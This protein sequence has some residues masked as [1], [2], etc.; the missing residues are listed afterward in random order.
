ML[1]I[2]YYQ[3]LLCRQQLPFFLSVLLFLF[4]SFLINVES[5]CVCLCVLLACQ[6]LLCCSVLKFCRICSAYWLSC[7]SL[8]CLAPKQVCVIVGFLSGLLAASWAT[9]AS[10]RVYETA[11]MCLVPPGRGRWTGRGL[12]VAWMRG[13]LCPCGERVGIL[14]S[15]RCSANLGGGLSPQNGHLEEERSS[16]WLRINTDRAS[17]HA[18][19]PSTQ[20]ECTWPGVTWPEMSQTD[21]VCGVCPWLLWSPWFWLI[22]AVTTWGEE[23]L[24]FLSGGPLGVVLSVCQS[25][26]M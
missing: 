8:N 6:L 7:S 13:L 4:F 2:F 14:E 20:S 22:C 3:P 16:D 25:P 18:G 23:A 26:W 17:D 19:L 9:L 5:V 10:L 15:S 21:P 11:G 12:E 24:L 1:K